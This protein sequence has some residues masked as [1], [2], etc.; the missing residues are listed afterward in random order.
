MIGIHEVLS[1]FVYYFQLDYK[2]DEKKLREVFR[3][4]G[5][6]E[7]VEIA[8]D[9]DG[10]SRGFG[11]VEFDHPVEAVQSISMLNNQN[12]F[13]RRITVRMDRVAD[14]LDGPVRL[15]EGLKSIGMGLGANGAPLQDVASEYSSMTCSIVFLVWSDNQIKMW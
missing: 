3:L 9:K 11:T 15:P 14:R 6:V 12:L 10:K 13:E 7:N 4:A 1:S 5:K 2:V 8:L